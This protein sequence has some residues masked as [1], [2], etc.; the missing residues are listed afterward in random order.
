MSKH[1]QDGDLEI[2]SVPVDLLAI[3]YYTPIY[4]T[5]AGETVRKHPISEAFW[6]QIYPQ[7]MYDILT[8][9]KKDY[10]DIPLTITEN[11]LPTPDSLGA[12]GVVDDTGRIVFLRDHLAAAQRAITDGVNLQSYHVWSLMDNFEWERGYDQRWGLVYVD[13]DTQVRIP[14][15]SALWF[16]DV[17]RT[18]EV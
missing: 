14:K 13:Y 6:Q 10:G 8:R 15:R 2:I 9:V 3:Q 5:A 17:I 16:S 1:I 4:V 7:G 18:N 12:D 11:G